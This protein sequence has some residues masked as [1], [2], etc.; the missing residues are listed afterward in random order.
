[1]AP[2]QPRQSA[3]VEHTLGHPA[4]APPRLPPPL[5]PS[6]A[7][8]LSTTVASPCAFP[9]SLA[10]PVPLPLPLLLL[11][12]LLLPLPPPGL[13]GG[14]CEVEVSWGAPSGGSDTIDQPSGVVDRA[15]LHATSMPIA[16]TRAFEVVG[17]VPLGMET[18]GLK[19]DPKVLV[20]GEHGRQAS[21]WLTEAVANARP[22]R[23]TERQAL[24]VLYWQTSNFA[25]SANVSFAGVANRY[26][27]NRN[28]SAPVPSER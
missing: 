13:G 26:V 8:P 27:V 4:S 16:R 20:A 9:L 1:M 11:L 17:K 12:L 28:E 25:K 24:V 14:G 5:L 15:P 3:T 23:A 2:L 21:R 6:K 10:M 22:Q 7:V 19:Q 18:S